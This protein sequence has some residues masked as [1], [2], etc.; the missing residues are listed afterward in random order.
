M[1]WI[2]STLAG[3]CDTT[4]LG[5]ALDALDDASDEAVA[6][7]TAADLADTCAFD[8]AVHTALV[9]VSK[10]EAP[11]DDALAA[12]PAWEAVCPDPPRR[13]SRAALWRR[14]ELWGLGAFT[15]DD[16]NAANGPV[17]LPLIVHR[18]LVDAGLPRDTAQVVLRRLAGVPRQ[19]H[20]DVVDV[21]EPLFP[22]FP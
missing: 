6:R 16:W 12:L 17:L 14:C 8:D 15:K 11:D 20:A 5:V 19:S 3:P 1:W 18:S 2:A 4:A 21:F 13:D 7:L 22:T 9:A 10:G